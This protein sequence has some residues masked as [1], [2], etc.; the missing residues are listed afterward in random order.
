MIVTAKQFAM[1]MPGLW[2]FSGEGKRLKN[3]KAVN[4]SLERKRG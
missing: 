1:T 3:K 2:S 4:K